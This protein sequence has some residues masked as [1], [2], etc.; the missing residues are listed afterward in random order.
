MLGNAVELYRVR[1]FWIPDLTAADPYFILPLVT[2]AMM[3]LQTKLTPAPADPQQRM[4]TVMM[5]VMFTVFSIF[6]P[7]G[8][9]LYIMTNTILGMAQQYLMNRSKEP[10]VVPA[11]RPTKQPGARR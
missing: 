8:L 1:L 10:V 7:A 9:T 4:M 11:A 2:G 3:Y 6:L 5:P